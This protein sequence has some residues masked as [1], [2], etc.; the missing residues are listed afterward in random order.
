MFNILK[1]KKSLLLSLIVIISIPAIYAHEINNEDAKLTPLMKKDLNDFSGKEALMLTV[2]YKPG[3]VAIP[4]RHDAHV[5][6][7]VLE[8]SVI[9]GLKGNKEVT[10]NPGDTFY[11]GPNDI[12]TIG[13]NPNKTKSAKLLVL[14]LKN[15]GV[16]P[17]IPLN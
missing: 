1:I 14:L 12:H 3:E 5:F 6:V 9:M 10:L 4:H 13:R 2:I 17:V 15:E 7:Y 8:G 16:P 11:E